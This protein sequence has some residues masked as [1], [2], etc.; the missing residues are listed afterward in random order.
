MGIEHVWMLYM[1]FFVSKKEAEYF[2][3]N[4]CEK[5]ED[6]LEENDVDVMSLNRESVI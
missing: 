3:E 4:G 5:F 2:R 1:G 6:L